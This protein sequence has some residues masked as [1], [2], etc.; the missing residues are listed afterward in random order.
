MSLYELRS[1]RLVPVKETSFTAERLSERYDLQRLL[2]DQIDVIAPETLVLAEEFCDWEDSRRRIDLLCLDR[3]GS[4]VVVELKSTEDGGHMELQA[5]RYAAMVS[6]LTFDQAVD[7][8]ER[9]LLSRG[10]TADARQRILSFLGWDAGDQ[11][12]FAEDVRI[13]LASPDFSKEITTAVLWLNQRDLDIRCVRV[14]PHRLGDTLLLDVQQI[15]PLPESVEYQVRVRAKEQGERTARRALPDLATAWRDLERSCSADQAAVARQL[16]HW[17]D[18]MG[19]RSFALRSGDGIGF[20]LDL[21]DGRECYLCK[22]TRRGSVQVW[23]Q[24][25]QNHPPFTDLDRRHELRARLNE[26]PEVE[27]TPDRV[28]GKPAIP[29]LALGADEPAKTFQDA[30]RWVIEQLGAPPSAPVLADGLPAS[31][32]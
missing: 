9:Y 1:E 31:H 17:F 15:V 6:T 10:E 21:P 16:E 12:P 23:F 26:I 28:A 7:A 30:W 20:K 4:L 18:T 8:H 5:L 29:L 25:L 27:I 3:Q 19:V 2:R 14:R 32:P 11:H 13:V 24:Y 22:I